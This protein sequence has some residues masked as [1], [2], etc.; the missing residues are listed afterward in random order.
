MK[1]RTKVATRRKNLDRMEVKDLLHQVAPVGGGAVPDAVVGYLR[2][3][4]FTRVRADYPNGWGLTLYF[5]KSGKITSWKADFKAI[6]AVGSPSV[7][8]ASPSQEAKVS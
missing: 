1:R 8:D 2:G 5:G 3:N 4:A 7:A 6:A